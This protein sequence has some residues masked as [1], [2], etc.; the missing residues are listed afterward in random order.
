MKDQETQHI[1][2]SLIEIFRI[3]ADKKLSSILVTKIELVNIDRY[4]EQ[5]FPHRSDL[6]HFQRSTK[7]C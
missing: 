1:N 6:N 4:M 7:K 3:K 5:I 2:F